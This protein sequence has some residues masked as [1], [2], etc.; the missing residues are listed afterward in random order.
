M[1][2]I[3]NEYFSYDLIGNFNEMNFLS[4]IDK[5]MNEKV[6]IFEFLTNF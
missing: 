5:K 1:K 6:F 3:F 2:N 4:E